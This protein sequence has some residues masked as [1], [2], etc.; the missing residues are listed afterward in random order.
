[1]YNL[2]GID[3]SRHQNPSTY[4]YAQAKAEGFSFAILRAGFGT[5]KDIAFEKHYSN[6]K[7]QGFNVGAYWYSYAYS[8]EEAQIEANAFVDA[9]K[10]KQFEYPVYLDI[11]DNSILKNTTK[12]TRDEIVRTFGRTLEKAGYYFGV[13]TN[14][15][16][17]DNK[18]SGAKLN[19]KYDWWI[20]DWRGRQPQG[21]NFG[22]WQYGGSVN[23]IRSAKI[24]GVV[25]DQNFAL[26][27]YPTLIKRVGLNGFSKSGSTSTP[28]PIRKSTE[29]LVNEVI[30]GKWGNGAERQ[31]KL[32]SA[33]YNYVEIQRAVNRKLG[34]KVPIKIGDRV[35]IIGSRYATGEKIPFWVK[36][37]NYTVDNINGDR[38]RI[39]EIWSWVYLKDLRKK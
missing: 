12:I 15:D 31:K 27:D 10:G 9:I 18:I 30:A 25:T 23:K 13:Y 21:L 4:P 32:T 33:G 26:K 16:W 5:S 35:K 11:E 2:K 19:Q 17:F 36:W 22:L 39:K 29:Q 28:A 8:V 14:K 7:N 3:I 34:V 20:A 24:G 6:C 37:G 1:M 38:A